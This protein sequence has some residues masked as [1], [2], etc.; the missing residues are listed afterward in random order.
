MISESH[1]RIVTVII[2]IVAVVII[3]F[4]RGFLGAAASLHE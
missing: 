1:L 2:K 4:S 3:V